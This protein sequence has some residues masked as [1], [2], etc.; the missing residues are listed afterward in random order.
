M[1]GKDDYPGVLRAAR[2]LQRDIQKVTGK[3]PQ[4]HTSAAAS[5]VIIVGTLGRHPLIDEL[6]RQGRID[7]RALAGQWEG[8][9]I[10][11]VED[12]LPGVQR[13]LVIAGSDKRGSIYGIYTLSEQI[14]VSPWHW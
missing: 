10:Q 5:D 8:F 9:L 4:W 11:A 1:V 6:A 7:T 3:A 12:P 14:G 2:D 13:A